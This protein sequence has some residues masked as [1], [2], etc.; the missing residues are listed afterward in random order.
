M[1]RKLDSG[2][3]QALTDFVNTLGA[4]AGYSNTAQWAR[5]SGYAYPN[6]SKLRNAK[7]AIDG[8]N[9]LRLLQAAAE[10]TEM[11]L[12]HLAVL[13]ARLEAAVDDPTRELVRRLGELEALVAEGLTR[14]AVGG[15][16][17]VVRSPDEA[18]RDS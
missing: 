13:T 2:Q 7:G 12:E 17:E 6:L 8:Y 9:L 5:D 1:A 11:P 18:P 10:R 3:Q 14:L 4:L 16:G 15:S